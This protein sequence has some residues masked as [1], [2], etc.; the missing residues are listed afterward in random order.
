MHEMNPILAKSEAPGS[1]IGSG[2]GSGSLPSQPGVDRFAHFVV[3]HREDGELDR[4]GIGAM[5][6]TYRAF[7][8]QLDRLVALKTNH[9]QWVDD[10]E[11][12][13]RFAREAKAAARL[14]HP[15]I[16]SVLF[17]GEEASVCFYVM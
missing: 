16:A 6:V 3:A 17:Q 14:Q 1:E 2:F 8:T 11:V 10:P 12:R 9:P 4:L 13:S 7:D 15:N 5:G